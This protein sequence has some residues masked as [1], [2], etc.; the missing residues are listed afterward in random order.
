MNYD[1]GFCNTNSYNDFPS[2]PFCL[3]HS[4]LLTMH[5]SIL[6]NGK[7]VSCSILPAPAAEIVEKKKSRYSQEFVG[8]YLLKRRVCGRGHVVPHRW[9]YVRNIPCAVHY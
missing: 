6:L 3:Y 4:S 8:Y 5:M 1:I 7:F 9:D 2:T